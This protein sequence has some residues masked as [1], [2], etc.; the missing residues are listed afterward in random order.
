MTEI[1][2]HQEINEIIEKID[3]I[4]LGKVSELI[5]SL[6]EKYNIKEDV[7]MQATTASTGEKA[8]EKGGN[9]SL[10]LVEIGANKFQIYKEIVSIVK[11]EKNEDIGPVQAKNLVE[12]EDKIILE[13]IARDKAEVIKKRLE[14][15]GAKVEIK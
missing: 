5:D 2:N 7:V 11:E 15:K 8:E 1:K 13:N 9:V 12:K 4:N 10:K 3:K 14:E 6:K